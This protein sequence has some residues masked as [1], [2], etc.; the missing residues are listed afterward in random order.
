MALLF[1]LPRVFLL[2]TLLNRPDWKESSFWSRR[3]HCGIWLIW[4][5]HHC[6]FRV[7]W[8][9]GSS[10]AQEADISF[11]D[12]STNVETI[13]DYRYF[14]VVRLNVISCNCYYYGLLNTFILK[15]SLPA[16]SHKSILA[17]L[18]H[19]ALISWPHE[20]EM[21]FSLL[22]KIHCVQNRKGWLM[23]FFLLVKFKDAAQ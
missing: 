2:P 18:H 22:L 23:I 9:D 11:R 4:A 16:V 10:P 20:Q 19:T 6:S 17:K 21:V 14:I 5:H 12:N 15:V 7:S 1:F 8:H 3:F 13:V